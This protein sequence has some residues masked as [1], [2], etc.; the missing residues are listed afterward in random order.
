MSDQDVIALAR[1]A[2]PANELPKSSTL[3][4]CLEAYIEIT[5]SNDEGEIT[6]IR[7]VLVWL[8]KFEKPMGWI[9][10]AIDQKQFLVIRTEQSR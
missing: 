5:Q 1:D 10:F 3:I 4:S 2:L 7:D 8:V 6:A 9:E